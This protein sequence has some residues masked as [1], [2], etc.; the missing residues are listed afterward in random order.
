MR[1]TVFTRSYF[2]I[3]SVLVILL[4]AY[5]ASPW[6][7]SGI[8]RQRLSAYGATELQLQ[9]GYPGLGSLAAQGV[10][11]QMDLGTQRISLQIPH[12]SVE[13]SLAKILDGKLSRVDIPS[14]AFTALARTER[15]ATIESGAQIPIATFVTGQW[16]SGL[17]LDELSIGQLS[18]TVQMTEEKRYHLQLRAQLQNAL[19]HMDG[20][21]AQTDKDPLG[22]ILQ[23]AASGEANLSIVDRTKS[24]APV[25]DWVVKS[26]VQTD[27]RLELHGTCKAQLDSLAPLLAP[28]FTASQWPTSMQGR[29]GGHWQAHLPSRWHTDTDKLQLDADMTV[30]NVG[31]QIGETEFPG[32]LGITGGNVTGSGSL[33]WQKTLQ[34]TGVLNLKKVTGLYNKITF[35]NVA[36]ELP[37]GFD[38][39]FYTH[40]EAH[41]SIEKTDIGF[42]VQQTAARFLLNKTTRGVVPIVKVKHFKTHLLDGE[43][44]TEPFEFDLARE[45]NNIPVHVSGLSLA[46]LIELEQQEGV[47]GTGVLDGQIPLELSG[48]EIVVTD[49][50]LTAREPGGVI[51]YTPTERIAVLAQS[52]MSVGMMTEALSDFHYHRLEVTGDYKPGGVLMLQVRLEGKNPSWQSG[53]PVNLNLNL[54]ENIPALLRSLQLSDEISE[55]VRK[56]YDKSP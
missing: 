50:K 34:M 51:R 54:Q 25:F 29:L 5:A 21:I 48:K 45:K 49:G 37:V 11:M 7:I 10:S 43:V 33:V 24:A 36:A 19:L 44:S 18:G 22:F 27:E 38:G 42:P 35:D 55:R 32:T 20:E 1:R 40:N 30:D 3:A 53:R 15:T 31:I 2:L 56:H 46:K 13:Y 41:L 26:I 52:N 16:L 28:W 9:T 4:V 12:I 47:T 39:G 17:P 6:L 14:I 8:I 23:S